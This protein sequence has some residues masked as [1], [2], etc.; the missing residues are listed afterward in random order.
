MNQSDRNRRIME[1]LQFLR[2]S[3][4]GH[5]NCLRLSG[6]RKQHLHNKA[7]FELFCELRYI[8]AEVYTEAILKRNVQRMDIINL[9]TRDCYEI[10]VSEKQLRSNKDYDPFIVHFN[11]FVM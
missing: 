6:N 11:P 4:R 9:V 3:N 2:N 8:G 5:I 1:A 10:G 7:L